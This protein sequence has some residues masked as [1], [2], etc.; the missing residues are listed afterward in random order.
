MHRDR[1]FGMARNDPDWNLDR[2]TLVREGDEVAIL[3]VMRRRQFRRQPGGVVP[4]QPGDRLRTLLQPAV[5]GETAVEDRRVRAQQQSKAL[6]LAEFSSSLRDLRSRNRLRTRRAGGRLHH[7]IV[8][9]LAPPGLEILRAVT[10]AP[11]R[12]NELHVVGGFFAADQEFQHLRDAVS[13]VERIDEGLADRSGAVVGQPV[14]P[15]LQIVVHRNLPVAV[16][17]RLVLVKPEMH[18]RL[19]FRE[20][21]GELEIPG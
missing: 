7:A 19:H 12:L 8:Q 15:A 13:V 5:V 21:A 2:A 10:L 18:A 16:P 1:L 4:G 9:R 14:A 17:G 6:T 3:Q 20:R 11:G